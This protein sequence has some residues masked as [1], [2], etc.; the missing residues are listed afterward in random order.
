MSNTDNFKGSINGMEVKSPHVLESC[1]EIFEAY[2]NN[3]YYLNDT[4][5]EYCVNQVT[6]I[7][8]QSTDLEEFGKKVKG[9]VE[10]INNREEYE[11]NLIKEDPD[12][13]NVIEFYNNNITEENKNY[14]VEYKIS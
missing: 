11:K 14:K 10:T 6:E 12:M 8:E 7:F 4:L 5:V 1:K 2:V 3:R 9:I 13:T